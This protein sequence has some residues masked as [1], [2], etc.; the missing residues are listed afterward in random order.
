MTFLI[1]LLFL[2]IVASLGQAMFSMTS[3][4]EGSARMARALVIRVGLSV[5]LFLV[6]LAEMRFG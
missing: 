5:A 6:L 2:G 4:P 1:G 3:G